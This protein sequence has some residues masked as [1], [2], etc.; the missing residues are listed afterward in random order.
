MAQKKGNAKGGKEEK[1]QKTL[2]ELEKVG[3]KINEAEIVLAERKT[4]LK[5]L[6][7]EKTNMLNILNMYGFRLSVDAQQS[8]YDLN[9]YPL[10]QVATLPYL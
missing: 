10:H 5:E 7:Q 1:K 9:C 4:Y 8:F 3:Q 2:N 6:K